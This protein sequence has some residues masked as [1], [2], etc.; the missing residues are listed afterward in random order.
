M[1]P[2]V[3]GVSF[4]HSSRTLTYRWVRA[5]NDGVVGSAETSAPR[6]S[7]T[8][9]AVRYAWNFRII[10][11]SAAAAAWR[12][13]LVVVGMLTFP[14]H[15]KSGGWKGEVSR[16]RCPLASRLGHAAAD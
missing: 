10:N 4:T 5:S 6:Y 7:A 12:S 8:S 16:P 3:L 2:K 15:G 9:R 1:P 11:A 13:V 14:F